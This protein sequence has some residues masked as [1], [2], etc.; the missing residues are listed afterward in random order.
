MDYIKIIQA[1]I[2]V[3][4]VICIFFFVIEGQR[5]S[6]MFAQCQE[7]LLCKEGMLKGTVCDK[8]DI[9]YWDINDITNSTTSATTTLPTS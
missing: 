3:A 5:V 8:Y 6:K 1:V 4:L 7:E 2:Q 9:D